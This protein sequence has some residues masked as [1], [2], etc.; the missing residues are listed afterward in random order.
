M[1]GFLDFTRKNKDTFVQTITGVAAKSAPK[2]TRINWLG[3]E[4]TAYLDNVMEN[5]LPGYKKVV[6]ER[7]G[8]PR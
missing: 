4:E 6:E 3:K 5:L 7:N 8:R 1:A 2:P